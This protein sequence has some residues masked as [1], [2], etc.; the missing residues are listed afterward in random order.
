ME[1]KNL[2]VSRVLAVTAHEDQIAKA[3]RKVLGTAEGFTETEAIP[4]ASRSGR[5]L[6]L[7]PRP[8]AAHLPRPLSA[9]R[10][11]EEIMLLIP[12]ARYNPPHYQGARKGW[13]VRQSLIGWKPAAII[14]A[15]WVGTH[16]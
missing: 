8:D 10:A 9:E 11:A 5:V 1:L 2:P 7:V 12:Q 16:Q 3:L 14:W 6:S 15:A 13:E 4:D